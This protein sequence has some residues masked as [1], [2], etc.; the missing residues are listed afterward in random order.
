MREQGINICY[1]EG[2]PPGTNWRA[3]IGDAL[4]QASHVLIFIS[5]R[6][7]ASNH[8]NRE[9]NLALDEGKH[10][11]PVYLEK[12]D[13]TSDLKVGLS[14]VQALF[15][16]SDAHFQQR[17]LNA[18]S[19][20]PETQLREFVQKS[21]SHL[22]R[23]ILIALTTAVLISVGWWYWDEPPD[24]HTARV[25]SIAV[26]PLE[27]LSNQVDQ[28]YFVAGM[29]DALI[30][31]LARIQ[32]LRVISRKSTLRYRDSEKS[33]RQI[34]EELNVDGVVEGSVLRVN[35]R[36]R[37]QTQLVRAFP[38]EMQIWSNSYD[39]EID[40][41][42]ALQAEVVDAIAQAIEMKLN[43]ASAATRSVDPATYE[44]YLK[45]MFFL[46]QETVE[47]NEKGIKYLHEAVRLDPADPLAYAALA[48][49][50][51][52][53]AH[54]PSPGKRDLYQR[55]EAAARQALKLDNTLAE[56]HTA[57]AEVRMYFDWD[58]EGSEKSF[59][60]A[61]ELNPNLATTRFNYGWM[62]GKL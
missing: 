35:G 46:N 49:G 47:G 59:R 30:G 37:I 15:R 7:L 27:N 29:H 48:M 54:G 19:K 20:T 2:I 32:S 5:G 1:D 4:L 23:L 62:L 56:A 25:Q 10:I 33:L 52:N 9:I 31:E 39:R 40:D 16:D 55:A 12:V 22:R 8:C 43:L 13:L 26:L 6:S 51:V 42:L 61:I 24:S 41:V 57:I 3:V 38:E 36:V 34:A 50:Y 60:H 14:R 53:I 28:E 21:D 58:W 11:I 18:F 44:A 17:L 45:G